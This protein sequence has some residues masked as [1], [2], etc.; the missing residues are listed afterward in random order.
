MPRLTVD[1]LQAARRQS[2]RLGGRPRKP[3]VDEARAAALERLVPKALQV[4]EAHLDSGRADAWRPALRLLE[5]GWG[6]PPEKVES[7]PEPEDVSDLK[8]MSTAEL[9]A[10]VAR[11]R[12]R[13]LA[14][15]AGE[16][17]SASTTP[18]A[19]TEA[20]ASTDSSSAAAAV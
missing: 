3:T 16:E 11:G 18:A 15:L 17:E 9:H 8:N 4:L 12:A 6:K 5:H 20:A 1:E 14:A 13:R 19:S 10:L 7:L 2:G